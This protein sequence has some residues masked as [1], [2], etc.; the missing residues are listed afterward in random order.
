MSPHD[1]RHT[2]ATLMLRR[3]VPVEVVSR[4]IPNCRIQLYKRIRKNQAV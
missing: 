2:A 1:L 4:M 3:K